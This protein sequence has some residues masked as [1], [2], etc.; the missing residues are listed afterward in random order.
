MYPADFNGDRRGDLFLYNGAGAS[1]PNSGRWFR[2]IS[3]ADG[4]F[5]YV[6]G[7]MRWSPG[8]QVIPGDF[9]GDGLTD[10]V[11]YGS[12]GRVF[13]VTFTSTGATY[14][15]AQWTPGWSI[16]PADFD[17]NGRTDLFLYMRDAFDGRWA[18]AR[19][20][21]T[22]WFDLSYSTTGAGL[23]WTPYPSRL[24]NDARSDIV[25]YRPATGETSLWYS[26]SPAPFLVVPGP[27][28]DADSVL[29]GRAPSL[30]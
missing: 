15:S 29:I 9:D 25:W 18:V 17:G 23:G 3:R 26:R 11:L 7:D 30:P 4:S 2:V 21:A 8:W 28:L 22:G 10:L 20:N 27:A 5:S 12:D 24:D 6:P 16:T 1:D 13:R 14:R 19:S